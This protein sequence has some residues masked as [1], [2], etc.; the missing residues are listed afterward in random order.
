MSI[1]N[2]LSSVRFTV[3][4]K[5]MLTLTSIIWIGFVLLLGSFT[6]GATGFG[7]GL[8]S[9]PLLVLGGIPLPAAIAIMLLSMLF[10]NTFSCYIYR[11]HIHW[12]TV[13]PI[14][15]LHLIGLPF[16]VAALL[17]LEDSQPGIAKMVVGSMVILAVFTQWFFKF[18][19]REHLNIAWGLGAGFSS[20]CLEGFIGMGSPPMVL[21]VMAHKWDL[22]RIRT[23]IWVV[24][25]S[26]VVPLILLLWYVFGHEIVHAVFIG[27]I[28]FPITLLGTRLGNKAGHA[29]GTDRLRLAAYGL[30][31][32]LGAIS[33]G[34][35]LLKWTHHVLLAMP[36]SK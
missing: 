33:I 31:V 26:D 17:F 36:L 14:L 30:L 16:G 29:L 12:P 5:S 32:L 4:N 19:P 8:V 15:I 34:L 24:F 25:L 6:Q 13:L 1:I 21:Y 7:L 20:G 22:H 35:P 27:V 23:T 2:R 10:V 9:I 11:Q 3:N 18:K 28:M